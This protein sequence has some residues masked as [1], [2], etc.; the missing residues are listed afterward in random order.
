M[1]AQR[2]PH[3]AEL[4]AAEG[5]RPFGMRFLVTGKPKELAD[6]KD[7]RGYDP[8]RQLTVT[9]TGDPWALYADARRGESTTDVNRDGQTVDVTDPY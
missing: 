9:P 8:V 6:G 4:Q 1:S 2:A 5:T 3:A 7:A